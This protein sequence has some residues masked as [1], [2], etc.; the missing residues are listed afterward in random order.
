VGFSD[1]MGPSV[2]PMA[3]EGP[4]GRTVLA[5]ESIVVND[6]ATDARFPFTDLRRVV[7]IASGVTVP[8]SGIVGPFG[9]L[10]AFDVRP[11]YYTPAEVHF[12]EAVAHF[13][14]TAVERHRSEAAGRQS[15]RLEAVGRLASSVAHDFNNLLTAII[16]FGELV[17]TGLPNGDPLRE[18]VDEILK[19][20]SRAANLTKQLLTFGRQQVMEPTVV[21]LNDI[22]VDMQPMLKQLAG[23][24]VVVDLSLAPDLAHV[25]ADATQIEQVIVNLCVNARDAMPNGGRISIATKDVWLDA[26]QAHEASVEHAGAYVTLAV[27][28]T[29]QGM[30]D[31]MQSRIFEPFFTTKGPEKGTGLG[32][33]TVYG[34]VKQSRG[35]ISVQSEVGRGTTFRIL[36]PSLAAGRLS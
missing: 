25:M 12:Q 7:G 1:A 26:A 29:G 17:H 11:R 18:D 6:F 20:S 3:K 8:I 22:V 10:A 31:D 30:D 16:A 32:L 9:V 36:L 4:A 33:A 5:D 35:E 14:S 19:A 15:Q 27:T 13:T 24:S 28:D 23:K 2:L 34:I 21:L